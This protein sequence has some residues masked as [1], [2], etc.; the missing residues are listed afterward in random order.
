VSRRADL[1]TLAIAVVVHAGFAVALAHEHV[2]AR[3]PP[4]TVELEFRR[5]PPPVAAGVS[6]PPGARHAPEPPVPHRKVALRARP[7][8]PVHTAAPL[9]PAPAAAPTPTPAPATKP[10]YGVAMA[11]TTEVASAPA[12]AV[13][14]S[15]VADPAVRG[16]G[17]G[18]GAARGPSGE[19][20]GAGDFHPASESDV[21]AMPEIDTDACGRTIVYPSEAEQAGIEGDVRLRIS[22]NPD[23]HVH[24][25]NVLSG[26][27]HGLDHVAV[28]AIKH[29]CRFSPAIGRDGKPVAFIVES[30][31]FHFE[32]PR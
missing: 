24:A 32:L 4:S 11:S 6:A 15:A 5:Q 23:G 28:E 16:G 17:P 14:G 12:V 18:R 7:A 20:D 10:I 27:G 2:R 13:G 3:K 1:A 26:L 22:L 8:A 19:G 30:Y 29:R 9:A 21:R 25:V 31:T